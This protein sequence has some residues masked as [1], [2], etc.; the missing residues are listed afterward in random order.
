MEDG[1]IRRWSTERSP[2]VKYPD[3]RVEDNVNIKNIHLEPIYELPDL[4]LACQWGRIEK[5][6]KKHKDEYGFVYYCT[7]CIDKDGKEL[8]TLTS[9]DCANFFEKREFSDWSTFDEFLFHSKS[10]HFL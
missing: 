4:T 6:F 2:V 9:T 3:G 8:K 1:F 5:Q 7:P 10:I